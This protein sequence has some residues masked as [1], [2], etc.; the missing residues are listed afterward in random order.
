M[1]SGQ[2]VGREKKKR[3]VGGEGGIEVKISSSGISQLTW[4]IVLDYY[5]TVSDP[6]ANDLSSLCLLCKVGII[7]EPSSLGC[8]EDSMRSCME[9]VS[10]VP[11]YNCP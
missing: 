7:T 5:L 8:F 10:S 6:Q 2:G 9:N 3:A 11:A 1:F 4:L